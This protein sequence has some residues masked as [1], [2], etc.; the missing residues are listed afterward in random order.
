MNEEDLRIKIANI[1]LN[2]GFKVKCEVPVGPRHADMVVSANG[3][4]VVV[5]FKKDTKESTTLSAFTQLAGYCSFLGVRYGLIVNPRELFVFDFYKHGPFYEKLVSRGDTEKIANVLNVILSDREFSIAFNEKLNYL[6]DIAR[7]IIYSVKGSREDAFRAFLQIFFYEAVRHVYGLPKFSFANPKHS[8]E[9]I[10]N[11]DFAGIYAVIPDDS[12]FQYFKQLFDNIDENLFVSSDA[13]GYIYSRI[14]SQEDKKALGQF[15]TPLDV[16]EFMITLAWDDF[17]NTVLDPACGSGTFLSK[18]YDKLREYGLRH[19]EILKRLWGIDISDFAVMLSELT[20]ALKQPHE[21]TNRLLIINTDTIEYLMPRIVGE[22]KTVS[23]TSEKI[24]NRMTLIDTVE[25]FPDYFDLVIM[26]PPYIRHELLPQKYKRILKRLHFPKNIDLF[27]Y[28]LIIGIAYSR[29]MCA[30]VPDTLLWTFPNKTIRDYLLKH[31]LKYVIVS[32]RRIFPDAKTRSVIILCERGYQKDVYFAEV[33]NFELAT[34]IKDRAKRYSREFLA[35]VNKWVFPDI[36]FD[37]T[38]TVQLSEL[39][40]TIK[41]GTITSLNHFFV[42]PPLSHEIRERYCIKALVNPRG[43]TIEEM[44]GY[45]LQVPAGLSNFES[46]NI[47]RELKQY[48]RQYRKELEKTAV[49]RKFM[50]ALK[51]EWFYPDIVVN[52][53]NS[54]PL[55]RPANLPI[56]DRFIGIIPKKTVDSRLLIALLNS[57]FVMYQLEIYCPK[58]ADGVLRLN[59]KDLKDL[60][61]PNPEAFSEREKQVLRENMFNIDIIDKIVC[62]KLKI[63]RNEL[64]KKLESA[65]KSRICYSKKYF[66]KKTLK[67]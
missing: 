44:S 58:Y 5:E 40:D 65:R 51:H 23:L 50:K 61:V 66:S 53:L 33:E 27:A 6:V 22:K 57:S 18:A 59:T 24:K 38:K 25:R 28:F 35:R 39:T 32:K 34:K 37:D 43:Q 13:V 4:K 12:V 20:L 56:I 30:I 14:L 1:L 55:F 36:E 60:L 16:V 49:S 10:K 29:K 45:V 26:N 17:T 7:N 47:P 9:L 48:I 19:D 31:G 41:M 64:I 42:N 46:V 52:R 67:S 3:K 62:E 8:I 54:V 2:N 11:I 21:K 15:Y 63:N